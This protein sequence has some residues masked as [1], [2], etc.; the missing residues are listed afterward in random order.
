MTDDARAD[1]PG[2]DFATRQIHAGETLDAD[3]GARVGPVYQTA[4]YVFP[5]FD[6]AAARF[7]G[8]STGRAY[9][10]TENP[11]NALAG[12]RLAD[13]E[14]GRGGIV[15]GS[16]QA[17]ISVA[18]FALVEQGDRILA[19]SSLYEGTKQLFTGSMTRQGVVFD[20]LPEQASDEQWIAAITPRTRA[21]YTETIPNPKNDVVDLERLARI[22]HDA[23]IPLIVDSTVA[24]PYLCRPI[25]WGADIVIHSTSKWLAGHGAVIGGAIIDAGRFDW[26][27]NVERFPRLS[28]PLIAGGPTFVERFGKGAYL[29]YLKSVSVLDYGPT[30][31]PTSTLLLLHGIETLSLRMERHVANAQRIAEWLE[32]QP[33]VAS[34]DY[35]GLPSSPFFDRA[36]KYLPLGAGSIVSIDLVGGLSAARSFLE[37]LTLISHMTH[38]GDVRTLAIHMGTTISGRLTEEQRLAAGITPGLVRLSIGI[39]GPDDIIADLQRGLAASDPIEMP[40][41]VPIR[42]V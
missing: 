15:V 25:E 7:A 32:R 21:I 29:A 23:G 20:F 19:T 40:L 38:I 12:R 16:G 42:A 3:F 8:E 22:A 17:A 11:T 31:P 30:V 28:E 27:A 35:A 26:A 34:V 6:E 10:R 37:G 4:G 5:T 18:I 41:S 13:L 2:L 24:T 39:E 36:T 33:E 1:S 14:G 9:S